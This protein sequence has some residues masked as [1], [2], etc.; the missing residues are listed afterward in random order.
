M[1]DEGFWSGVA[2][3]G[4][5]AG[6]LYYC[7][8]DNGNEQ[9]TPQPTEYSALAADAAG[10]AS[11]E[12]DYVPPAPPAPTPNYS[13]KEGH[14]YFYVAAV[15]EEERKRGQASGR[16]NDYQYGGKDDS[17]AHIVYAPGIT[18]TCAVPCKIIKA[19]NGSRLAYNEGSIIGAV[20][21]DA[22][23]GFLK[24][25]PKAPKPRPIVEEP[26]PAGPWEKYKDDPEVAESPNEVTTL[27]SVPSGE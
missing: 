22:M 3:M 21:Q 18:Y 4:V 27:D 2:V 14:T 17:G 23:R 19:S 26:P 12:D 9:G 25:V 10:G 1:S 15:S 13:D 7:T 16:V 24:P 6:S 8:R 20:F 5:L 11:T